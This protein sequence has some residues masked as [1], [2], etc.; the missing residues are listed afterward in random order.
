PHT[1]DQ[2]TGIR[3]QIY[4]GAPIND[5]LSGH[6]TFDTEWVNNTTAFDRSGLGHDATLI[7]GLNDGNIVDAT[8]RQGIDLVNPSGKHAVDLALSNLY[9][10]SANSPITLWFVH[11]PDRIDSSS[12]ANRLISIRQTGGS[13]AIALA[14]GSNDKITYYTQNTSFQNFVDTD[15]TTGTFLKTA[16]TYDGTTYRAYTNGVA[17]SN[18]V[19]GTLTAGAAFNAY[20]GSYSGANLLYDGVIEDARIYNRALS[21]DEISALTRMDTSSTVNASGYLLSTP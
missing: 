17:D 13:S 12:A 20:I 3:P 6:W 16:V 10:S 15:I 7:G 18:V 9:I 5:G 11:T 2:T 1:A 4:Y 19:N 8:L 21:A 14:V